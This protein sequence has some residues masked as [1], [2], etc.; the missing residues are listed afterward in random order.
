MKSGRNFDDATFN[1]SAVSFTNPDHVSIVIHNYRWRLSL[2]ADEARYDD[3]EKRLAEGPAINVP[4]I[5]LEGGAHGAPHAD[6]SA[7]AKNLRANMNTVLLKVEYDTIY[8]RKLR[9][10]LPKQLLGVEHF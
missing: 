10:N 7:Y 1:K 8:R 2:A 4:I 3:L 6:S 5:T 9:E